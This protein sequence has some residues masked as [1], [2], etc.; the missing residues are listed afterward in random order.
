MNTQ[1][2]LRKAQSSDFYRYILNLALWRIVPFNKPHRLR[3]T[4]ITDD[5]V[6]IELP[7][8]RKNLNHVGGIHACALA[9]L[10]EYA[11]GLCLLK[12]LPPKEYRIVMK[13]LNMT[14]HY[15]A[16]TAVR[17]KFRVTKE[18]L[19]NDILI[20][21]RDTESVFKDYQVDVFDEAENHICTGIINWQIKPWSKVRTKVKQ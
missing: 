3:I 18:E 5:E 12:H 15:Q 17:V 10:C 2:I 21:L 19:N 13:G 16:K 11:S 4:A 6:Q 7:Y 1:T 8:I 20:P 9:T 14:Y